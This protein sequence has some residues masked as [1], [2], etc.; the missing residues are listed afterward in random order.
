MWSGRVVWD[1]LTNQSS[2]RDSSLNLP[3][4]LSAGSLLGAREIDSD[5]TKL[6]KE[7]APNRSENALSVA[8]SVREVA[9]RPWAMSA[10]LAAPTSLE[11]TRFQ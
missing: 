2:F 3:L 8:P 5:D 1:R 4:K 9:T 11:N 7:T 6:E 10:S